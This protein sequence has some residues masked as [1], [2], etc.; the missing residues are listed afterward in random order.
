MLDT[1]FEKPSIKVAYTSHMEKCYLLQF[2]RR[3]GVI[4][5]TKNISCA[6]N[7]DGHVHNSC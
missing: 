7:S 2:A 3:A 5:S 1:I 4:V 6:P